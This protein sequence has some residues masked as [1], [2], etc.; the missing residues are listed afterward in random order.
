MVIEETFRI[1]QVITTLQTELFFII[2][3]LRIGTFAS[4][5]LIK[6]M[7]EPLTFSI[8]SYY[9]RIMMFHHSL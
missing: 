8:F 9:N 1:L 7:K 5:Q 2:Y 3:T 4:K 6:L